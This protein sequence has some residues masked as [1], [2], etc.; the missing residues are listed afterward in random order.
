M[1]VL[2]RRPTQ[3]LVLSRCK[4]TRTARKTCSSIW[5]T[6]HFCSARLYSFLLSEA[7]FASESLTRSAE[8]AGIRIPPN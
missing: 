3:I 6:Y 2:L 5:L 1:T 4:R 8:L 7:G